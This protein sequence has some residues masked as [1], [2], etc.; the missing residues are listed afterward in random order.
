MSELSASSILEMLHKLPPQERL[1]VIARAL[2]EIE[3]D[4]SQQTPQRRTSL[5]GICSDLG[6]APSAEEID[7]A[8]REM[9]AGFPRE[10]I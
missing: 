1:K 6:P 7:Q 2:P 9:W 4:L 10:D 8:R 5:L 3:K